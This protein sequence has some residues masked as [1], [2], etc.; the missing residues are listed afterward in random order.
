MWL[1]TDDSTAL[2]VMAPY[3]SCLRAARDVCSTSFEVQT[4]YEWY[5]EVSDVIAGFRNEVTAKIVEDIHELFCVRNA[6]RD[7]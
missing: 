6:Q 5:L 1:K 7:W 3:F 4:N 2:R